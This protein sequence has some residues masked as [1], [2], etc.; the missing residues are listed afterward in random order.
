MT[1]YIFKPAHTCVCLLATGISLGYSIPQRTIS[2]IHTRLFPECRA[3]VDITF[4]TVLPLHGAWAVNSASR[5]SDYAAGVR[6][7]HLAH[8]SEGDNPA[9]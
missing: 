9:E 6:L 1:P 4:T 2:S 7:L 5:F 3:A 8:S